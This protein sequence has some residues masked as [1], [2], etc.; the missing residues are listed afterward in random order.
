MR[1]IS[2]MAATVAMLL[3]ACSAG[4]ESA[5]PEARKVPLVEDSAVAPSSAPADQGASTPASAPAGSADADEAGGTSTGP[6]SQPTTS[7]GTAPATTTSDKP[8]SSGN[9]PAPTGATSPAPRDLPPLRLGIHTSDSGA[10]L[11]AAGISS[12]SA[13][14]HDDIVLALVDDVNARGGI[15]GRLIEPVLHTTDSL[16]GS[17]TQQI[18]EACTAFTQDNEVD[19][20]LDGA[21]VPRYEMAPCLA[22]HDVPMLWEYGAMVDRELL[23]P[24]ASHLFMPSMPLADDLGVYIDVLVDRGFLDRDS[25]I[26]VL[27]LDNGVSERFARRVIDPG[28]ARHG[29]AI[30]EEFAYSEPSGTSDAGS[31]ATQSGNAVI[32]MRAAGVDRI[33]FVPSFAVLP[34]LWWP[35]ADSQNYNPKYAM[36]TYDTPTL[37]SDNAED[38][39][40]EGSM[41]V[42]WAPAADTAPQ[43]EERTAVA[44]RCVDVTGDELLTGRRYCNGFVV[45][46][47]AF[48]SLPDT[49]SGSIRAA[50]EALGAST[51]AGHTFRS[52]LT[53]DRHLAAREVQALEYSTDCECFAYVG[54]RYPL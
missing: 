39:Q 18:A 26:G 10:A 25:T 14:S 9:P 16:R 51:P 3:T 22:E 32:R 27:R 15:G 24:V 52:E 45:M 2:A 7:G 29:L 30:E 31:L 37:Q 41:V 36:L 6:E 38:G 44:Q 33:L 49:S 53:A 42:G 20:V 28:L 54:R 50:L 4:G 46:E 1:R 48:A 8:G 19:L 34:V 12:A 11:R 5:A 35:A 43:L 17:F 21:L 23:A 47:A 40:L 13:V